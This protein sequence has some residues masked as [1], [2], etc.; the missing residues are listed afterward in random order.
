[1]N[2][3]ERAVELKNSIAQ[4]EALIILRY[5]GIHPDRKNNI[6]CPFHNDKHLGNAKYYPD[7]LMISCFACNTHKNVIDLVMTKEN[8][9]FIDAVEFIWTKILGNTLLDTDDKPPILS[10]KDMCEIGIAH[11]VGVPDNVIN[12]YYYLEYAEQYSGERK[13]RYGRDKDGNKTYSI[14]DSSCKFNLF[15]EMKN[16]KQVKDIIIRKATEKR[17]EYVAIFKEA[18]DDESKLSKM[19]FEDDFNIGFEF[20]LKIIEKIKNLNKIIVSIS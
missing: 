19:C 4:N 16:N 10:Y 11:P 18:M 13:I 3:Y 9:K 14:V 6:L 1:M 8:M 7:S 2:R 15:D 5:Y 20:L 17:D 12:V